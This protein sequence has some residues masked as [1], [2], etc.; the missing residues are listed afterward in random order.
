[1][2]PEDKMITR[3]FTNNYLLPAVLFVILPRKNP[4]AQSIPVLS[5]GYWIKSEAHLPNLT[6]TKTAQGIFIS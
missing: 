4:N 1:M 6:I 5:N 3:S 2:F